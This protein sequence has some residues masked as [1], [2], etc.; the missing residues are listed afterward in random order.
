MTGVN[1]SVTNALDVLDLLG[2]AQ[3]GLRLKDIAARLDLPESTTH[4]LL[5]SLS[6]RGF[7]EQ[8]AD[9]GI[10]VL[11]WKF[12]VL[13][14]ALGTD[15]R[16]AQMIHPYL[17]RL[18]HELGQT[19]NLAVISNGMVMY[20][21]S[22][23]PRQALA[24]HAAPGLTLPIH[25]T[26]LGK[27]MLAFMPAGERESLLD[28][29]TLNAVTPQTIT[30]RAVLTDALDSIRTDGFALDR[31]EMRPDVSCV[32]APL[33]DASGRARAAIS[34]SAPT[35][36]L[37]ADWAEHFPAVISAIANEASEMLFGATATSRKEAASTH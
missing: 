30:S 1:Q 32:A 24:V 11:G 2:G 19:A 14:N 28:R 21:D 7:V 22:Q 25:S 8:R 18:V 4:R 35:A 31:G 29:L 34:V 16:L 13:A 17:D 10:Y 26:S 27:V 23:S 3:Q 33:R 15:A 9:S 37:P 20:L 12:V 5:A 36:N 6:A